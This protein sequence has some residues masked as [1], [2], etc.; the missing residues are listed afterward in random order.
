M[1]S[2]ETTTIRVR[3]STHE[4]LVKQAELAGKSVTQVLEEA[5]QLLE[6][7]RMLDSFVRSYE[8]YGDEIREE[9]KDWL[10]MPSEGLPDDDWSGVSPEEGEGR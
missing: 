5:T 9:M 10:E 3:R 2:V 7:Q 1:A 6:E 4:R 8:K